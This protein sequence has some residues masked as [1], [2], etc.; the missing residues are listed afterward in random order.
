[1]WR[2]LGWVSIVLT[3]VLV[4]GSLTAYGAYLNLVG[5]INQEKIDE[6][7]L[8]SR[9][10][11]VGKALNILLIGSDQRDGANGKY[12]RVA[13]ERSDTI[14]LAHVSP[15]RDGATMISFPR[16]SMVR[17][18]T[19]KSRTGQ[20]LP[21]RTGMINESFNYGGA[22]CTWRT[23][24]SLTGIHIDHFA[25]VD[26]SGFKTVVDALGGVE[27]CLSSPV[28]D[29]K[30]KLNLPAGRQTVKGED[31]LGYVR[32]RYNIGNDGSDLGRIKRQQL[33]MASL[34]KKAT[35]SD[36]LTDPV[37]LNGFLTAAARTVTTD[38]NFNI[39]KMRELAG[40]VKGLSTGAVRFV[41]VPTRPW[42]LDPNRVEWV[43]PTAGQLFTSIKNDTQAKTTPKQ[44]VKPK[45]PPNQVRV[46]VLNGTTTA[47]LASGVADDLQQ[48]G[49]NI[50][51]VGNAPG[52]PYAKTQLRYGPNGAGGVD[53]VA[54]ALQSAATKQSVPN[55][56]TSTVY[57]VV[58]AD[59][60]GVKPPSSR[61]LS[62]QLG[63]IS[64]KTNICATPQ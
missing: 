34:V 61:S 38:S 39:D 20:V 30:S 6:A 49:F 1:M 32:L 16:D 2:V 36:I 15:K 53:T 59:W 7:A 52:G 63:G 51:K 14:I 56:R 17:L 3:G 8:G 48:R 10:P 50:A 47:G 60:K 5:S 42:T 22:T 12:G 45:L 62:N 33:F 25:K 44:P 21:A 28:N 29:P 4:A 46:Q 64:A 41:T 24:E 9:P 58:G 13:G 43:Q 11:K 19:C 55:A 23:I 54:V 37:Q 27:V 35:S 40:S 26:F 57:L 18:P 31:A